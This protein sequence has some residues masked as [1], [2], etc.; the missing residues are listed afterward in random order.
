MKLMF[1]DMSWAR[2]QNLE[3]QD[4][5]TFE[6]TSA[7]FMQ[8][9]RVYTVMHILWQCSICNILSLHNNSILRCEHKYTCKFCKIAYGHFVES[10]TG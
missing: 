1:R 10:Y 4:C 2:Q 5:F 6:C 9:R 7:L 3:G 8:V